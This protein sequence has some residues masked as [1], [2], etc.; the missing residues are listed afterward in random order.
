M[1]IGDANVWIDFI[2]SRDSDVGAEIERLLRRNR[3]AIVGVVLAEVLR[4]LRGKDRG[5]V[6][7][8]L[9]SI[10]Y[11][12]YTK[13]TWVRAGRLGMELDV[14]GLRMAMTDV[15]IAAIVLEGDHQLFT[16]DQAF[17]RIPGLHLYNPAGDD[18]A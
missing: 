1:I 6:E 11:V 7:D 17:S 4:G 16:R 15:F 14:R 3:M 2:K 12:E 8:L 5:Q 9:L 13:A 10:P 18:D